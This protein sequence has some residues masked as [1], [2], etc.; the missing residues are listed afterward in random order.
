MK[1]FK[2]QY[3]QSS[4]SRSETSLVRGFL[5]CFVFFSFSYKIINI[6]FIVYSILKI[7]DIVLN[8]SKQTYFPPLLSLPEKNQ[9][10]FVY[11][12]VKCFFESKFHLA[13]DI[14]SSPCKL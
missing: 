3:L 2:F 13:H 6:L 9:I 10:K 1:R 7:N 5:S 11:G 8:I 12:Y 4:R 14:S